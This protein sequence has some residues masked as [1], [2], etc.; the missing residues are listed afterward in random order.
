[1]TDCRD[2]CAYHKDRD[3]LI[4]TIESEINDSIGPTINQHKAYWKFFF[5]GAAAGLSIL[6]YLTSSINDASKSIALSVHG[7][8]RSIAAQKIKNDYTEHRLDNQSK[9]IMNCRDRI[10][11]LEV[12]II[13]K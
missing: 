12:D 3:A 7:L 5:W 8:Q 10:R 13:K 1:M 2:T 9:A 4:K 11:E 6:I